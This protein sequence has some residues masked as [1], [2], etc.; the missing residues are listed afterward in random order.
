[1]R[2]VILFLFQSLWKLKYGKMSLAGFFKNC[3]G[4]FG[5][6]E[7]QVLKLWGAAL[8][9]RHHRKSSN[10]WRHPK[11]S[12]AVEGHRTSRWLS[13]VWCTAGPQHVSVHEVMG[14]L[15]GFAINERDF[16]PFC[17]YLNHPSRDLCWCLVPKHGGT[18][19]IR[20]ASCAPWQCGFWS[21]VC[22]CDYVPVPASPPEPCEC[23]LFSIAYIITRPCD[24]LLAFSLDLISSLVYFI[25]LT[26]EIYNTTLV[27]ALG[28][29]SL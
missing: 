15:G 22:G 19:P 23:F 9:V 26:E 2:K 3:K 1:M 20:A 28:F 11:D 7:R 4:S 10:P 21:W 14:F 18:N 29:F 16:R 24:I 17:T 6:Q 8:C 27:I 5:V 25:T 12:Q 13:Q